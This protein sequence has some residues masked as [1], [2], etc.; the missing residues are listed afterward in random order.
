MKNIMINFV[1]TILVVANIVTGLMIVYC[2]MP[3]CI[4]DHCNKARINGSHYCSVHE[5]YV[6]HRLEREICLEVITRN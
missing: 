4:D 1:I 3:K 5:E 6:D 2:R